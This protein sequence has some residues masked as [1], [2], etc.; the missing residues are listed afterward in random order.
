MF[1]RN[2]HGPFQVY[3]VTGTYVKVQSVNNPDVKS[4]T[5]SLQKCPNVRAVFPQTSLVGH[6][7]GSH[8]HGACRT[9]CD[10]DQN[11]IKGSTHHF[12]LNQVIKRCFKEVIKRLIEQ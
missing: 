6:T 7:R 1:D 8:C 5:I 3:E 11:K 10:Q 4:R 12:V 9:I 2:F